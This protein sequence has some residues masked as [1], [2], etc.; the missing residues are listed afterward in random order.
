MESA[1]PPEVQS[2]MTRTVMRTGVRLHKARLAP[3]VEATCSSRKNG[4]AHIAMNK[5]Q[6]EN[7]ST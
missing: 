6:E 5:Y 3:S 7:T 1:L 2:G 4:G